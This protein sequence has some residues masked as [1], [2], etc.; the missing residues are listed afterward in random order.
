MDFFKRA[1]TVAECYVSMRAITDSIPR[2][3]NKMFFRDGSESLV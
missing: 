1:N 3:T 2:V